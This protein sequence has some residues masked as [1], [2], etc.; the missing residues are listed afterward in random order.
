VRQVA[1]DRELNNLL[2][3]SPS[4]RREVRNWTSVPLRTR[5]PADHEG[6]AGSIWA[7]P[8]SSSRPS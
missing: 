5:L 3:M 6:G 8:C 4:S 2:I 1:N 7:K